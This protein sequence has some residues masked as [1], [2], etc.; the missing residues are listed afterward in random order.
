VP[1]YGPDVQLGR[2]LCRSCAFSAS[3]AAAM[4]SF[5]DGWYRPSSIARIIAAIL[6]STAASLP[7]S[8]APPHRSPLLA[9]GLS[10]CGQRD[11][12]PA[13]DVTRL[14]EYACL[15]EAVIAAPLGQ[16]G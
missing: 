13:R 1:R 7:S 11:A 14:C 2:E 10:L 12:D 3:S 4:R 9:P 15:R 16:D 8:A 6:R 5:I